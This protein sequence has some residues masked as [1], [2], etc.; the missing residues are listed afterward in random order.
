MAPMKISF[1]YGRAE[2]LGEKLASTP[3]LPEVFMRHD[4]QFIA[5]K[6]ILDT[7]GPV[8]GLLYTLG[9]ALISYML[10]T[11]GEEHWLQAA[12]YAR[13]GF[14]Q[15]L[16]EF[17]STSPS[18][19][20]YRRAKAARVE[21]FL[22]HAPRLKEKLE[23]ETLSP[24]LLAQMLAKALSAKPSSKTIVFAA[25]MAYYFYRAAG[26]ETPPPRSPI[27]V[28]YR[29]C[30]VTVTS[31][32][33]STDAHPRA[34]ARQLRSRHRDNVA[35]AWDIVSK[36]S[37]IAPLLLDNI[38][39]LTG[40]CIDENLEQPWKIPDCII[41]EVPPAKDYLDPLSELWS[42]LGGRR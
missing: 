40:R 6:K 20:L 21:K 23:A 4:P 12:R 34:A 17:V 11:R 22:R 31:G 37:G 3:Q 36:K 39:W 8:D 25:K 10:S 1:N 2:R 19:A 5:V 33:A 7:L 41:R 28:D 26:I 14:P 38:V 42:A 16:R 29:V 35:R 13:K 18:M 27:P 30:L 15:A 9:V 32:I 24:D